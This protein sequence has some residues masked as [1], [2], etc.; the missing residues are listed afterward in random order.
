MIKKARAF[1]RLYVL[2][3][4]WASLFSLCLSIQH[5]MAYNDHRGRKVDSLEAVLCSEN[6]PKGK[7]LVRAY[8]DLMWGYLNTDGK[9][10]AL[11]AHKALALSYEMNGLNVR[12]DALRILGLIAYGDDD[13]EAAISYFNWALA[14]TDSMRSTR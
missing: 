4:A 11:Y 1:S 9:R 3:L 7:A 2:L 6:P 5:A 10:S 13:Y 8:S 12:T 14:V